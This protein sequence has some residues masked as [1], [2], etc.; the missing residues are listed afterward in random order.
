MRASRAQCPSPPDRWHR[1]RRAAAGRS[2][3]SRSR[4]EVLRDVDDELHL[5]RARAGRGL[6]LPCAPRGRNRSRCCSSSRA[7]ACAPAGRDPPASTA[8]GRCL[9]SELIAKPKS[10]SCISGMPSIIAK[11]RRSRRIW[12]NSLTT[13]PHSR[14]ET[15]IGG[16]R[17]SWREVVLRV[18]SIRWMKTSSSPARMLRP[19]V[20]RTAERRDGP[21]QRRGIIA[22][23]VQ[24]R[25]E[26]DRLL[27]AGLRAQL[28]RRARASPARSPTTSCSR[29]WSMTSATVPCVSRL[30]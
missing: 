5:A 3:R 22:A 2:P 10:M 28:R 14:L 25:A 11:V 1:P 19:L 13:M 27:H 20:R 29:A 4:R 23:H 9:G 26:G 15:R 24:R 17:G 8:A 12:M 21:L 18:V 30:P 6:R 16:M 7:A